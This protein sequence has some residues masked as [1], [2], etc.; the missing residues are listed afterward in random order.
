[1]VL[2]KKSDSDGKKVTIVMVGPTGQGKST[3][4]NMVAGG[5]VAYAP[6]T[7]SDDFDSETLE[8]A[9]ADFTWDFQPFRAV[10]TIGFL[11][12]RMGVAQNMD[13]F[14]GFADRAPGG[15]DVFLFVLK[16]GRFTEQSLG[17]IAAFR[18]V[19][20]DE[21]LKHCV[22]IF[23]HCGAEANESLQERCSSTANPHL[24]A[25]M[26]CCT[27]VV[28]VDSLAPD[29]EGDRATVL[30]AIKGTIRAN[31]GQKYDNAALTEA[32]RHREELKERIIRYLSQERREA[33]EERLEGLFHGRST[34]EQVAK[35]VEDAIEREERQRKEEDERISLQ[36]LLAAAKSEAQAWKE[37]AKNVLMAQRGSQ[38]GGLLGGCCAPPA[39]ASYD[40]CEVR[41]GD[42]GMN[43]GRPVN[44]VPG[45]GGVQSGRQ[46]PV[47]RMSSSIG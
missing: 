2:S 36:A 17:Q 43:Y 13:K 22:L 25:A 6:F 10:D 29:R 32:R 34:Y 16:K 44:A 30:E 3:L 38:G 9:H 19:A 8:A 47:P 11:D 33:M 18:A 37:V 45:M 21:A 15:I 20:G 35:A 5:G 46:S 41:Y 4:G 14:A 39:P 23:T 26:D 27:F 40:A 42:D 12:T 7:T 31:N 24:R 28:G 1:M